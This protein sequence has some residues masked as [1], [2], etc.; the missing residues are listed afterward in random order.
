MTADE[1]GTYNQ[2]VADRLHTKHKNFF[3]KDL[4]RVIKTPHEIYPNLETVK[5]TFKDDKPRLKWRAKQ[6]IDFAYMMLYSKNISTYYMQIEDDLITATNFMSE[7]ELFLANI[8]K[9]KTHWFLLEF[10]N[11]GF[12]GK[13][14]RSS[15]LPHLANHLLDNYDEKPCDLLLGQIRSKQGQKQPIHS[16]TSLFQHIG[17]YSSLRFKVMPFLDDKFKDKNQFQTYLYETAVKGDNPPATVFTDMATATK[18]NQP[19]HAYD[20]NL[21]SFFWANTPK[22]QQMFAWIFEDA[23]NFTRIIVNTGSMD[24]HKD[25]LVNG[26]LE[27]ATAPRPGQKPKVLKECRD[28]FIKLTTLVLGTADTLVTGT[29]IPPN[30]KCLRIVVRRRTKSWLIVRD[31]QVFTTKK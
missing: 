9:R 18:P 26:D 8:T 10:S 28:K 12:I 31:L 3:E 6:N 14:L 17:L 1:N 23:Q 4:L 7:M 22:P 21:T 29:K 20:N 25:F 19:I 2:E 30:I 15:D 27:Y 13:F 16:P 11:L 24:T 5:K